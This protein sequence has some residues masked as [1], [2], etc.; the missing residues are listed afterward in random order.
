MK[1]FL[2]S[3]DKD[4]LSF[5]FLQTKFPYVSDAKLCAGVFD[6]PQLCELNERICF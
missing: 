6:G 2:K 3:L 4:S 5:Q 1:N